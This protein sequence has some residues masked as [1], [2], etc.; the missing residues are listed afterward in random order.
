MIVKFENFETG[1]DFE[2]R[3]LKYLK[4][5][6]AGEFEPVNRFE[7]LSLI[8]AGD[9]FRLDVIAARKVLMK[10]LIRLGEI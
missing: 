4:A 1:A 9:P 8:A 10:R 3:R 5:V 6:N 2:T 7:K